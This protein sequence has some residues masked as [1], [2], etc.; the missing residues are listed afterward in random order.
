MRKGK[1][2]PIFRDNL[3]SFSDYNLSMPRRMYLYHPALA[4]N[5]IA[6]VPTP[7]MTDEGEWDYG[8]HLIRWKLPTLFAGAT[9]I[10]SELQLRWLQDSFAYAE[11]WYV[12]F[13]GGLDFLFGRVALRQPAFGGWTYPPLGNNYFF[14]THG[15]TG[16]FSWVDSIYSVPVMYG[17]LPPPWPQ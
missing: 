16:G 1:Y 10:V 13:A 12:A 8:I 17:D 14:T 3:I 6:Y 9:P 11:I 2:F 5:G 4:Y 15:E 7:V